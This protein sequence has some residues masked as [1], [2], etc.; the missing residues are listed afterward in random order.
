M[1][2]WCM[3]GMLLFSLM[4]QNALA[5]EDLARAFAQ[6]HLTVKTPE[7]WKVKVGEEMSLIVPLMLETPYKDMEAEEG[8]KRAVAKFKTSV[9]YALR[10]SI[11]VFA[12]PVVTEVD[13]NTMRERYAQEKKRCPSWR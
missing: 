10:D 8:W 5:E 2:I 1:K 9:G 13:L 11:F 3:I 12:Y 7:G 4:A 6:R